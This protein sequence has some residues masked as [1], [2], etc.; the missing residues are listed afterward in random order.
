[1]IKRL[2]SAVLAVVSLIIITG[3]GGNSQETIKIGVAGPLT[4]NQSKMGA[5]VL[6]GVKLAVDQWNA[7]GGVLGKK[8]EIIQR[9]DEAKEQTAK[10]VALELINANV[11][12]II[13]HFN[14]GCT[15]PASENYFHSGIPMI[16]PSAT[17]PYVTE[18]KDE[19]TGQTYWNVFRVCGRD[20]VQGERA[21]RYVMEKIKAQRIAVVHD[22]T[23]YGQGLADYFKT[24]VEKA[25]NSEHIVYYGGFSQQEK[26]FKPYLTTIQ[27]KNPEVI[28]FGGMYDQ[29]GLFAIQMHDMGIKAVLVS[30]DGVI[31]PEF[32]KTAGPSAEGSILTFAE[33]LPFASDVY[34][35]FPTVK[36]FNEE[37][38]A[39][40]GQPGP[41]SIYSYDA[42]N[43][44]IDSI[45][46]ANSTEGKKIADAIRNNEH[47]CSLGKIK[48][49][50]KGDID[51]SFYV[52]WE[53]KNGEFKF[54]EK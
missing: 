38:K 30:G 16:T 29:G 14:S 9:D 7:R 22:K 18:R 31:D 39:K 19:K 33:L 4:G 21:A 45:Q 36:K 17:N 6:N 8:I 2:L 32:L 46:K 42:A 3:C 40:Y 27:E 23:A 24:A 44:L 53:V 28:F 49:N 20:D 26:N 11:V 41:Y 1:M 51:G 37:Y 25:G 50:E 48:F 15:L 54:V 34:E 35:K 43:I 5:D 10:T 52:I 13:G 47:E 12:G